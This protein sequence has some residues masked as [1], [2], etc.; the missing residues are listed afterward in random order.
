MADAPTQGRR[1]RPQPPLLVVR[2]GRSFWVEARPPEQWSAT[3]QALRGGCYADAC[4]YDA[5]GGSWTIV[6]ATARR[7]PSRA[8]RWLPWRE[9]PVI[10]LLGPRTEAAVEDIASRIAAVLTSGNA[11]CE[12]L[13][14]VPAE[15][16]ERFKSVRTH[17]ELIAL[18]QECVR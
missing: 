10:I 8:E 11:F 5:T 6:D 1:G 9:V 4:C 14:V 15:W 13:A 16:L 18:A 12:S 3:L 17:A 7:R 2:A